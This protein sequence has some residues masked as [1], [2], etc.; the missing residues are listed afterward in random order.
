MSYS[1]RKTY[2]TQ[3]KYSRQ[4]Q[5]LDTKIKGLIYQDQD[6]LEAQMQEIINGWRK[7]GKGGKWGPFLE[8]LDFASGFTP[9]LWDYVLIGTAKAANYDKLRSKAM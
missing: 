7:A 5:Q 6:E 4:A 9:W 8:A 2:G 1:A 3:K